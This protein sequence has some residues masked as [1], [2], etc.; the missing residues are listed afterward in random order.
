MATPQAFFPASGYM[1][2]KVSALNGIRPLLQDF[3]L[4]CELL[5]DEILPQEMVHA[6]EPALELARD[7]Y[8]PVKTGELRSSGY[9]EARPVRGRVTAEIG[10]GKDGLAPYAVMVHENPNMFHAPPTQYK[11]LE[12]AVYEESNQIM[13][14]LFRAVKA[15]TRL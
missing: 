14:R 10:F 11:F 9:V 12:R 8:C 4:F 5:E 1:D 7:T 3:G 6:L 13:D 15:R 2:L